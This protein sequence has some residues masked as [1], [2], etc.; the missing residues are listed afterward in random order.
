[1]C[2]CFQGSGGMVL[3]D[4]LFQR[5]LVAESRARGVPVIFDEVGARISYAEPWQCSVRLPRVTR[6]RGGGLE[7]KHSSNGGA[8]CVEPE[9]WFR[10]ARCTCQ[11]EQHFV[12]FEMHNRSVTCSVRAP[13]QGPT[14]TTNNAATLS[15]GVLGAVASGRALGGAA[16]GRA[17]RHR[18]LRQAADRCG[19][20][21]QLLCGQM[22]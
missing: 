18:L 9:H 2:S 4:P 21:R 22:P 13:P 17:A 11:Q 10:A 5:T 12:Q 15:P 3:V 20:W 1:M 19:V 6:P 8:L 16:A 7:T 14:T